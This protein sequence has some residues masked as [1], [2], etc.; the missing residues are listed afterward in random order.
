MD[1]LNVT[2]GIDILKPSIVRKLKLITAVIG[3]AI[4]DVP[5]KIFEKLQESFRNIFRNFV[6]GY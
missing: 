2:C 3:G 5:D 6:G 4:I 1:Y